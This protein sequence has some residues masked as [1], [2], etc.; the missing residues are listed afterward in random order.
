VQLEVAY[1]DGEGWTSA[2]ERYK[3]LQYWLLPYILIRRAY[4]SVSYKYLSRCRD[5]RKFKKRSHAAIDSFNRFY[6]R[7]SNEPSRLAICMS[8]KWEKRK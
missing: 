8:V 7:G 5:E 3:V 1:P 4:L 6:F 2:A